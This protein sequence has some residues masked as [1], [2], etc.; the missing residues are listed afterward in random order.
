M[1]PLGD[2]KATL[3][4]GTTRAKWL[5]GAVKQNAEAQIRNGERG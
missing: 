3:S 2:A 4:P 1:L 5:T